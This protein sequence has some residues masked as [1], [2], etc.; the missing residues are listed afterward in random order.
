MQGEEVFRDYFEECLKHF[1]RWF[2]SKAA[3]GLRGRLD[4]LTPMINFEA[5]TDQKGFLRKRGMT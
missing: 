1:G 2:N 4:L 5:N 3:H